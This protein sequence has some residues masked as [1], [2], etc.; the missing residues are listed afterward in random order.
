MPL[1]KEALP[2]S[3]FA[4]EPTFALRALGHQFYK[5]CQTTMI[6]RIQLFNHVAARASVFCMLLVL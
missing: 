2:R 6:S 3:M 5:E 4:I 1:L